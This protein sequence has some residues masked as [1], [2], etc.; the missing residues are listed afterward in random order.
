ML[1]WTRAVFSSLHYPNESAYEYVQ[2]AC[3]FPFKGIIL[4]VLSRIELLRFHIY[5]RLRW[6]KRRPPQR[7]HLLLYRVQ[8][9]YMC[10]QTFILSLCLYLYTIYIIYTRMS[11]YERALCFCC[12]RCALLHGL[13][14]CDE[15]CAWN[16][17]L[18]RLVQPRGYKHRVHVRKSD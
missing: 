18:G 11:V 7:S 8:V 17:L 13:A 16:A 15:A 5:G 6:R 14:W 9:K 1:R 2:C 12:E 4:H 10:A 3:L